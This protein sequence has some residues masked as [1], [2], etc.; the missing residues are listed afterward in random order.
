MRAN[1]KKFIIVVLIGLFLLGIG[2]AVWA[3]KWEPY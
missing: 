3:E 2:Q 1:S